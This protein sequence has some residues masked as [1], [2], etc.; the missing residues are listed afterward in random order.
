[1]TLPRACVS[2]CLSPE[3]ASPFPIAVVYPSVFAMQMSTNTLIENTRTLRC[4][5]ASNAGRRAAV[6][7]DLCVR[8]ES[9][10]R[11]TV[12]VDFQKFKFRTHR[13]PPPLASVVDVDP[14]LTA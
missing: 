11:G 3:P 7:L 6:V 2:L 5:P 10:A 14:L 9:T 8:K 1:M 12:V 4:D 13:P